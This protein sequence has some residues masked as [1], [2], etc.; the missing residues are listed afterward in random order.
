MGQEVVIKSETMNKDTVAGRV[1]YIAPTTRKD[2][3]ANNEF[4]IEVTIVEKQ[5]ALKI[6]M[7]TRM[8]VVVEQKEDVFFTTYDLVDLNDRGEDIVYALD[9]NEIK[10][11]VVQTGVE[12]AVYIEIMSEELYEGMGLVSSDS[13]A[14]RKNQR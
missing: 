6:G 3:G 10:E 9:G 5:E 12:S 14:S 4:E 2:G 11:I 1:S 13:A 8:N 7:E